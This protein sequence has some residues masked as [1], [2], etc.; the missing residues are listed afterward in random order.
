LASDSEDAMAS[1]DKIHEAQDQVSALQSQSDDV[2]RMLDKAETI[3]AAGEAAKQQAQQLLVVSA[4][5][6]AVG[7][8]LL[9]L[10]GRKKRIG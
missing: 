1:S 10:G 2:Q 4:T 8:V 9:I 6:V 5:L 3:A 7:I